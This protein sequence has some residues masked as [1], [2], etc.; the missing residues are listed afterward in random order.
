MRGTL[1]VDGVNLTTTYGVHVSGDG[2]YK[3]AKKSYNFYNIPNKNGLILASERHFDNVNIVYHC[4][5]ANNFETN[6]AGLRDFLMS[7]DGYVKI[8][9]SYHND[10][11]RMGIYEGPFEPEVQPSLDAA[12]FNLVF[13]CKPQRW[14]NSGD[15]PVAI[16]SGSSNK[17][18]NPTKQL[19]RPL[20]KVTGKVSESV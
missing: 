14:L 6:I 10:E 5:I 8:S 11:Y 7:R 19:A 3:S 13:N 1:T 4:G 18:T 2:T 20:I 9:D 16:L 15:T 12:E 17:I